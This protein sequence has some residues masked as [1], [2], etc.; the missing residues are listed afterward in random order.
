[1]TFSPA[2]PKQNPSAIVSYSHGKPGW[3]R[4]KKQ[5]RHQ[6]IHRLVA[7]L[8]TF[9]VDADADIFHPNEDWTR[10]GPRKVADSDFVLVVPSRAWK[11]AW[12]RRA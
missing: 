6:Q 4:E 7:G 12:R 2:A 1:M 8:R 3:S 11:Q 10:W 5:T 9:G